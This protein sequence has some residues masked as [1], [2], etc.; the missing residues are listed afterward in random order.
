M[1]KLSL[2]GLFL[3]FWTGKKIFKKRGKR[4]YFLWSERRFGNCQEIYQSFGTGISRGTCRRFKNACS[5]SC[6]YDT[7]TALKR[8]PVESRYSRKYDSTFCR[9]E[10][11]TSE[12]QSR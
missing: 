10:E 6:Q 1:D 8:R 2:A 7:S 4:C 12:L 9:S 3:Y 11:H 5:S